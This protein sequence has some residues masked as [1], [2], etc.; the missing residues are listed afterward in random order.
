MDSSK[1][2][3]AE[4][5][6]LLPLIEERL[7]SGHSVTFSP[8]GVSMLPM[9]REGRD[10]VTLSPLPDR[11]KKH[12]LPLY[13]RENGQFVLHRIVRVGKTYRC[14]GD[15]QFLYE[16][17]VTHGQMIAVVSAFTRDGRVIPVTSLGYRLYC[18][19]WHLSRPC[20]R[21]WCSG[22]ARLRALFAK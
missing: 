3:P 10:T 14:I 8:C 16:D 6:S 11:L 18:R 20:R 4:L 1:N 22:A 5:A 9:L 7:A 21:L 19:I 17:G 2:K 15:N 12:D 13:R